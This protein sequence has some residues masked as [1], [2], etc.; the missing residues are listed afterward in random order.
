M[1]LASSSSRGRR[2]ARDFGAGPVVVPA[3]VPLLPVCRAAAQGVGL[4]DGEAGAAFHDCCCRCK[5]VVRRSGVASALR[6][7][8]T[9][10]RPV[11]RWSSAPLPRLKE[12][13]LKLAGILRS[14]K[15][16]FLQATGEGL[17]V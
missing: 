2:R 11:R 10:C 15:E 5:G 12:E 13:L 17:L 3:Y 9:R 7:I 14:G 16:W 8:G 6:R 1:D 4:G